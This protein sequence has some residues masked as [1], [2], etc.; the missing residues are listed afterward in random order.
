MNQQLS[1]LDDYL[2]DYQ[3][4]A[5]ESIPEYVEW[6]PEMDATQREVFHLE[7]IGITESRL[8][9]LQRWSNQGL[10][11]ATQR[12]RYKELQKLIAEYRPIIRRLQES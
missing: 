11:T 3:F 9:E 4:R 8:E 2:L 10:L 5:W 1:M 7:W 12:A 6:W